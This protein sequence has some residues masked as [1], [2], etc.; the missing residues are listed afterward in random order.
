MG[1]V[2]WCLG[3]HYMSL[4]G[5]GLSGQCDFREITVTLN[6]PSR[7]AQCAMS[8]VDS[9]C[10]WEWEGVFRLHLCDSQGVIYLLIS[11]WERRVR[12][13]RLV[14][15]ET[16]SLNGNMNCGRVVLPGPDCSRT[17]TCLVTIQIRIFWR[18][19][20]IVLTAWP[21]PKFGSVTLHGEVAN[22]M[23]GSVC[24]GYSLGI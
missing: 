23:G 12:L 20:T 21:R 16:W 9:H 17:G 14:P 24:L 15:T 19:G 8:Q 5:R 4:R 2:T 6:F 1:C 22:E 10:H 3:P 11:L 18:L 7:G 13:S